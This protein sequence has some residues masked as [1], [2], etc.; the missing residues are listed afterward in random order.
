MKQIGS[1]D[2]DH[3]YRQ[4]EDGVLQ[5]LAEDVAQISPP[6]VAKESRSEHS[7]LTSY[8]QKAIRRGN[9]EAAVACALSL[10]AT[11]PDYVWRRLR[12][13]AMEEVSAA[14]VPL[15]A[16]VLAVSGKRGL[17]KKLGETAV[18]ALLVA[19]LA[20]TQKCRTACDMLMWLPSTIIDSLEGELPANLSQVLPADIRQ[21]YRSAGLWKSVAAH[22]VRTRVGWRSLSKGDKVRRDEWLDAASLPPIVRFVVIR[23]SG[24]DTL[25]H[26]LVPAYQLAHRT[27]SHTQVRSGHP[28]SEELIGG[29]P[30]YAYCLFSGPGRLALRAFLS[31]QRRWAEA[32]ADMSVTDP[33]RAM[34][35]LI[36]Q[37]EG[38][39]CTE[40]LQ[41]LQADE[42][43]QES[44]TAT[45]GRFGVPA[46]AV[47][48]LKT[49][50]EECL[51]AINAARRYCVDKHGR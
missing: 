40:T 1:P 5:E 25:N 49:W 28:I 45:L 43:R 42:I 51:P 30:A 47:N 18:L 31:Q 13:I 4:F 37:V 33:L 2:V 20:K 6:R 23:G 15:V 16:K 38:G 9:E 46:S 11:N 50:V 36:F 29:V 17:Q 12:S 14:N 27:A 48:D 10:H 44:E 34:G 19:Q 24:T 3:S 32:L 35:H 22:S 8:W 39:L 7:L 41:F 26:L 21:I